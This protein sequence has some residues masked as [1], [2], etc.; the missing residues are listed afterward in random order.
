MSDSPYILFDEWQG[1]YAR[2]TKVM[3]TSAVRDLFAAASRS[4]VISLSGGMPD[5][6]VLPLDQ[7]KK[8]T[9]YVYN[10]YGD[11]VFQYGQTGG[12]PELKEEIVKL[13]AELGVAIEPRDLFITTGAQQ[14]LSLIGESFINRGDYI[15][16]EGPTYLG[17]LNAFMPF[18]PRIITVPF[19]DEGMRTDALE[20][21]L[22][23]LARA[24]G[25]AKFIY[26]IPTFQ[27]P[28]GVTMSLARRKRLL[29]L[30]HRFDVLLIEDDP[31]SRL[32]FA[33]EAVP[34][35]RSLDDNMIYLGTVSKIF[36][37]SM[38]TGWVVAPGPILDKLNMAKQGADLCSSN[39]NHLL[40]LEYFRQS[41]WHATLAEACG[42]Y[43]MRAEAMLAA[44]ER[45]FPPEAHWTHPEGGFFVWVTLPKYFDTDE[46]LAT[47]LE[48]GV[49][50]VPGRG[51]Y[52]RRG[53]LGG[54]SMRIAFCYESPERLEEAIKRLA[55]AIQ[56][57][58]ELYRAFIKAGVIRE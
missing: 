1:D 48:H 54:N 46:L 42:L 23:K 17:A 34:A 19:D 55:E 24:G 14:A 3:T 15:I 37:P 26:T 49:T 10:H 32:R 20:E 57:R 38:R 30:A 31:Y 9:T 52:P 25:Q 22:T 16:T 50:F 13:M 51:C 40:C 53:G 4:D 56:D 43:R 35:I 58:L 36:A 41:D 18:E 6:H 28:G 2:R 27:N 47:A 39:F 29:E 12:L 5:T 21:V 8:L 7:V 45:Y 11:S 44:L 33:G